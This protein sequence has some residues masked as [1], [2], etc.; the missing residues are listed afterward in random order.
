MR[1]VQYAKLCTQ[2]GNFEILIREDLRLGTPAKEKERKQRQ[3][4]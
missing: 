1:M 4:L 3:L 2:S